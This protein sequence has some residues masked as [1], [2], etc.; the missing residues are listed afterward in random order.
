MKK[1]LHPNLMALL[2]LLIMTF[3]GVANASALTPEDQV[4]RMKRG[5]NII[6]YDPLWNDVSQARF[7]LSFFK[8]IK[9]GG[10]DHVRMNLHTFKHLDGQN[11]LSPT[12]L[13]TLD[14]Y[15]NAALEAKLEVILDIHDFNQCAENVAKCRPK[16]MAVWQELAVRYQDKPDTVIF[17]ILNEPNKAVNEVWNE[18]L[19]ENLAIIRATNKTRNVIVGPTHWNNFNQLSGLKLPEADRHLIVTFHYYSPFEFTHQQAPWTPEVK[20]KDLAWGT[21]TEIAAVKSD[22]DT[23]KA[24]S[25]ANKRPIYVGEFGAYDKAPLLSRILYTYH[26]SRIAENSGFSWGYWQFDSDFIAFDVIKEKWNLPIY[27]ALIPEKAHPDVKAVF[28]PSSA[29]PSTQTSEAPAKSTNPLDYLINI[30]NV[31]NWTSYG[32]DGATSLVD[33]HLVQGKKAYRIALNGK[34]TNPWDVGAINPIAGAIKQNDKIVLVFWAR[35]E[36][37]DAAPT[38]LNVAI[39]QADAPYKPALNGTVT[40]TAEWAKHKVEGNAAIELLKGKSSV[41]LHV[42]GVGQTIRLGP[43]F[44][45]NFGQE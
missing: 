2:S 7:K 40:L 45:L 20:A 6:G 38:P 43:A 11:K 35:L 41:S 23:V 8:T 9:D 17:E 10:F 25:V 39:Q 26:V 16:L 3:F 33:D 15:V 18:M 27:G 24:W 22:F 30:P 13:K 4:A 32:A 1:I 42:G 21:E 36:K 37:K 44:V 31:S 5:V 19:A 34:T 29:P 28:D 14:T 12:F